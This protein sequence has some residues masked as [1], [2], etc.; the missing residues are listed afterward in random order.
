MSVS[1]KITT[2][3]RIDTPGPGHLRCE[4]KRGHWKKLSPDVSARFIYTLRCYPL[5]QL[6]GACASRGY[7]L[8]RRVAAR[9]PV[10]GEPYTDKT[11]PG[12]GV[13]IYSAAIEM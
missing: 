13:L 3:Y 5:E 7:P 4:L 11:P 1:R 10:S 12:E 2:K 8:A 9:V 6:A